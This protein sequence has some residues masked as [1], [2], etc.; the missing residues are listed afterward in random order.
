MC[1]GIPMR[2]VEAGEFEVVCER[3]G[4]AQRISLMLIGPQPAGT[5]VLTHLGSAIR[6]LDADEARAIDNA[7]AG[8]AEAVDGRAFDQLFEDLIGREPQLPEHLR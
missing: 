4:Q 7:L 6:I 2:V 3:H 1:I 8:L 5:F